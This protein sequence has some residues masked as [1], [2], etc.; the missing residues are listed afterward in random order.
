MAENKKKQDKKKAK[1]TKVEKQVNK[2]PNYAMY[3]DW[4]T[5]DRLTL[6]SGWKRNGLSDLQI[7]KNMGVSYSSLR[8][9]K[10]EHKEI[11]D[12]LTIGREIANYYVEGKLFKTAM[13]GNTTAMIFYLKNNW[14]DKYNDSKLSKEERELAKAQAERM[15]AEAGIS[16]AKLKELTEADDIENSTVIVNDMD[17]IDDVGDLKQ[18]KDNHTSE[19]LKPDTKQNKADKQNNK[20]DGGND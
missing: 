5:K 14:R 4:L 10:R 18:G 8:K 1:K 16:K 20:E 7:A 9:W 12:A 6:L 19:E 11:A 2:N 15:I 13:E 17:D 3:K